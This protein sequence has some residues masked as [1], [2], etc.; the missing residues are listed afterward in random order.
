MFQAP[1]AETGLSPFNIYTE[2]DFRNV[3]PGLFTPTFPWIYL[4]D[5]FIAP[6]PQRIDLQQPQVV[7]E[8]DRYVVGPFELGNRRGREVDLAIHVFGKNRGER[9][10]V[11]AF[12]CDYFGSAL[13][14]KTYSASNPS[15]TEVEQALVDVPIVVQDMYS[16]RLYQYE[17]ETSLLGWSCVYPKLRLKT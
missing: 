6:M 13:S 15:G 1:D 9:D 16:P 14:I 5:S 7:V 3:P 17:Q 11:A 8:V 4:L 2:T 10:D 12:I